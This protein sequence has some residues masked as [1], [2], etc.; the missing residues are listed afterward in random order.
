MLFCWLLYKQK[1][2]LYIAGTIIFGIASYFYVQTVTPI[3][4]NEIQVKEITWTDIYRI[5]GQYMRGFA[6]SEDGE[7]WYVQ[8]K[9]STESQKNMLMQTS[10]AGM[11][12]QVDAKEVEKRPASHAYAFDMDSYIKSNGAVGQ[13][14][15]ETYQ[16]IEKNKSF[17]TYMAE[18]RFAMKWHIQTTF[19]SSLQAEAEAL[20]IGSREQMPSDMQ[21]AYQTL[22]ITHLFAI[23]G[24]H[25]AL[26][27]LLVY[28]SMIRIGIR[29]ETANLLLIIALPLYAFIAGGAPS[30][31]RSV[32]VTEIV[33]L[34]LLFKKKLAID[35]AFSLSVIGFVLLT[36]WVI[37]QIGFQL[38][39]LAA[40]SLIY[41]T[42]LLKN[43]TSYV[44]QSFV[45]TALCQLIV[46]PILLYQFYEISISSFL[47]NLVFVPLFSF[48][49]LPINLFFLLLTYISTTL[50]DFLFQLYEPIR[51]LLG[52]FIMYL[53]S[54]PFQMWNP[55]KPSL[56]LVFTAYVTVIFFFISIERK[57]RLIVCSLLLLSPIG[58]MHIT[59]YLDSSTKITFLNVGQGDCIV[60]EMPY[61]KEVIMIDTGGLLRFE[62]EAWKVTNE[63]YEVGRQIVVP[64][65]KGKGITK[66]DT[67]VITHADAD[68]MEGAEEILGEVPVGEIHIT[69]GSTNKEGMQDLLKE[70]REQQI[71]MVEKGAG[72]EIDSNYFQFHYIYPI[73]SMYEGNNDSLVLSMQNRYFH[74][75]FM[76]DLEKE[77]E[78]DLVNRYRGALKNITLLKMGHH[79]SK[80][81]SEQSF[82]TLTNPDVAIITAGFGNRFGHPHPDV[83][84]RLETLQIPFL[85]TG[86][87]GAIEVEITKKGEILVTNFK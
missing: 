67:L 27:A 71:P 76:G 3:Q 60:I 9:I 84:E 37:F 35:D 25:V 78:L 17:L 64:F 1:H 65:L 62:Q 75:L 69:P 82:L 87:D 29:R 52:D 46:Y 22:G 11:V 77:G 42:V 38:S 39:Y 41:S 72:L 14:A 56:L 55:M 40:L 13:M 7:K 59:P 33:L 49:I 63:V 66:I 51:N 44:M 12:F 79:G 31:W 23:S 19:P 15:V 34:S 16:I 53:G 54:L 70:V 68:H 32:S 30:V 73:D 10:V 50:S 24:L 85:Q 21:H 4:A 61:R 43:S 48:I 80:T 47:A 86:R 2:V 45:I 5:N 81:S 28:E 83:V 8:L 36:P 6:I 57:K 74:G 26:L 58:I 20:L 18:K